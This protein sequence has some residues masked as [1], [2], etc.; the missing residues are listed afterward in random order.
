[1]SIKKIKLSSLRNDEHFPFHSTFCT[2]M[3]ANGTVRIRFGAQ[4][5]TY[6]LLFADEDA[7]LKKISKSVITQELQEHDKER[8]ALFRALVNGYK[9]GL[10]D[11]YDENRRKAAQRLKILFETYGNLAPKP[12][13]EQTSAVYNLLQELT[14]DYAGD[15]A[16]LELHSWVNRLRDKNLLIESLYLQRFNETASRTGIALRKAREKV[17][18][19][20]RGIVAGVDAMVTLGEGGDAFPNF[21]SNI[22][23]VIDKY[24]LILA[25]RAGKKK[26]KAPAGNDN[27][28]NNEV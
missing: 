1:M 9:V 7:A 22:N 24:N 26:P 16:A 23:V 18:E 28:N 21:V 5:E 6:R 13:N 3:E 27:D 14:G 25:Q 20:Y 2:L 8:D 19:A 10:T 4:F 15:V 17:D 12:L 11:S